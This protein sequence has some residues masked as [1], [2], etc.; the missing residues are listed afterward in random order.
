[1]GGKLFA[2]TKDTLLVEYGSYFTNLLSEYFA[3]D[4]DESGSYFI[5]RNPKYFAI[6]LDYLRTKTLI[7]D[8]LTA[9]EKKMLR[10][11]IEY[12]HIPSLLMPIHILHNTFKFTVLNGT[13]KNGPT[14]CD[15]YANT[16]LDGLVTLHNGIQH[17]KVPA[18][19]TYRIIA[20][21]LKHILN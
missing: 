13:G 3:V 15:Q 20:A 10:A 2:T 18:T 16:S 9:Q 4:T 21:G 14:S 19:G 17:W 6:I 1:M 11:E 5:D 8:T 7:T 12:Y